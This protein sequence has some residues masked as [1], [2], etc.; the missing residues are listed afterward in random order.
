M[1]KKALERAAKADTIVMPPLQPDRLSRQQRIKMLTAEHFYF[2]PT[3]NQNLGLRFDT[4]SKSTI[5][6]GLTQSNDGHYYTSVLT[7][8]KS[9]VEIIAQDL[10]DEVKGFNYLY[11]VVKNNNQEL[12]GWGPVMSY[13]WSANKKFIYAY[14]GKFDYEPGEFLKVEIYNPKDFNDQDA[15][16]ID[17]R[18][19]EKAQVEGSIQ[20]FMP[21]FPE[22][23][24]AQTLFSQGFN[25][26]RRK[27]NRLAISENGKIIFK[28]V[29]FGDMIET[30]NKNDV[31]FRLSDTVQNLYFRIKN[32]MR[33]YNYNVV[34]QRDVDGHT[35]NLPLGETNSDYILYKNFWERPGKYTLVLTPKIKA[36]GG[37]HVKLLNNLATTIGFTVLP[38]LDKRH[39]VPFKLFAYIILIILTTAGFIFMQY[40][41]RQKKVLAREAQNRQ[42]ATL[43]LQ[44]VR[45]QLNPH[46]IFNALAGIQNLMNKN[47]IE[48]ANKYLSKFARLTRNI[49]DDGSKE[50]IS[51]EH[52]ASLLTDYLQM[53]QMRFGFNYVVD[54][55]ENEIDQ[56]IEI[57]AMLLQP[58]VENAVKH[59]VSS[60][61][62]QGHIRVSITKKGSTLLLAVK[63]NGS[64][65]TGKSN[66][67]LGIK[68]C[69]D[70]IK[71]LNSIYKNT[72]IALQIV[73]DSNGT[74]IAIELQ[75]WI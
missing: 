47:E 21:K 39:D 65:F 37:H 53:E 24:G 69:E 14:L 25:E 26:L 6:Q 57:P 66:G 64:G 54:I 55:D 15:I 50:L 13:R 28:D 33:T 35:D 27:G 70:R 12:K 61:K 67:G 29:P 49:L 23:S 32:G 63:D 30:T 74:L 31:K 59:G 60:L 5:Y 52:E 46:F 62:E 68:L 36:P 8:G 48:N 44:S 4:V 40:R 38:P 34:L 18:K 72:H 73:S 42:I 7:D 1:I 58:F 43:Q 75:N 22:F 51:I 9:S 71:L 17:W 3:G 56:Q 20:Y 2:N 16:L 45:A 11:R 10:D 19:V 41:S